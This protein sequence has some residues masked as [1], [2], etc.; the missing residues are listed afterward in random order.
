[1]IAIMQLSSSSSLSSPLGSLLFNIVINDLCDI[2]NHS[3]YLHF[4]DGIKDYRAINAPGD[5]LL[6]Q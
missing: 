6:L 2:I 5:C 3:S 1:L 4:P